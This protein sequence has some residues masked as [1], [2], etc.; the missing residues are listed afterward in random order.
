MFV[1]SLSF[2]CFVRFCGQRA[3][4]GKKKKE[5][6]LL[7]CSGT[8]TYLNG[9]YSPQPACELS[10]WENSCCAKWIEPSWETQL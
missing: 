7:Y 8:I 6:K 3:I 1:F 2:A 4:R 9:G 10:D 5:K